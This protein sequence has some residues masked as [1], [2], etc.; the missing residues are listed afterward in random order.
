MKKRTN[1]LIMVISLLIVSGFLITSLASYFTSLSS[2]RS[3]IK[4][5]E[6]PMT[7]DNIYSEI[8][9]DLLRPIFISSLMA[10]DTF[11]R[12]WILDGE[13]DEEKIRKYLKTIQLR[14]GT[15]TSFL[16][17]EN[18][19]TYYHLNGILKTV[20]PDEPRDQWYFRVRN[21]TQDYEINVDPD[22]ANKDAMTVFINYKVHDY[23]NNYI[24]ATGVGLT[25]NAVKQLIEKYQNNYGCQIYFLDR[26]GNITLHG[27]SFNKKASNIKSMNGMSSISDKV[28]GLDN[29]SSSYRQNGE[30]IHLN[31]RYI[32]ELEWYLIVEQNEKTITKGILHALF[33][34]LN[35]CFL[36]TVVVLVLI[37][38]TV[39]P[40]QKTLEKMA[41]TDKLT[42]IYNRQS[43]DSVTSKILQETKDKKSTFS[44]ILFDIDNFKQINDK[45]G[46]FA[47]DKVIKTVSSFVY[48]QLENPELF[49]RWGGEEFIALLREND[50]TQ[51]RSVAEEIRSTIKK[52]A[53]FYQDEKI[54]VTVSL[55][56]AEYVYPEGIDSLVKRADKALLNAK[57]KGKDR[58][59]IG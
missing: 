8:Q 34:N 6:L 45:Y 51:A 55:G 43:F 9:R 20:S 54:S 29:T 23:E 1:Q 24:G 35:I 58:S 41:T 52:S 25:V 18:T 2:L 15:F 22:M 28:L 12:D 42:G 32:P 4:K 33:L 10:S 56:I 3:Q 30:L 44:I 37:N 46:H 21:I 49:F 47:G 48:N 17:S 26:Q 11:L 13:K 39:I 31:S 59:V 5:N 50:I 40:Y 14:Y 53:T 19:K 57:E 27:S 38:F 7:S 16:V 36:V